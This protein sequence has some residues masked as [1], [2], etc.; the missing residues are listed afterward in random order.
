MK[1]SGTVALVAAA[2]LVLALSGTTLARNPHAG[3]HGQ[4]HG[5]ASAVHGR[6]G[7][8][9]KS[10]TQDGH[11]KAHLNVH[12]DESG[13][14]TDTLLT[15]DAP[16]LTE[17][18]VKGSASHP[19]GVLHVLAL[20]QVPLADRPD[21]LD[22]VVHFLTGDV[23]LTLTRSG[24]GVAY[25]GD[26][27]VPADEPSGDVAIDVTGDVGGQALTGTGSGKVIA[28]GDATDGTDAAEGAD[29]TEDTDGTEGAEDTD[30]TEGAE[31]TDAADSDV[32]ETAADDGDTTDE[33][34]DQ[35]VAS[36]AFVRSVIALVESL[37]A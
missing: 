20:V 4:G 6:S 12:A 16:T 18:W 25:Q 3:T 33:A 5:Q 28:N 36:A 9:D 11:G 27:D 17:L 21:T 26:A 31:D 24:L 34:G 32:D 15:A 10:A 19:E 29:G 22:V 30:G 13:S 37:L 2:G 23:S 1:R 35:D 7:T 14:T 8:H